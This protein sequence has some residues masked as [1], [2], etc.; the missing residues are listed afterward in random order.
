VPPRADNPRGIVRAIHREQPDC[1]VQST[2][3][4]E[5]TKP[6]A[7]SKLQKALREFAERL[8]MT[9]GE[10]EKELTQIRVT[11]D[12]LSPREFPVLYA[13]PRARMEHVDGCGWCQDFHDGFYDIH[14]ARIVFAQFAA[15][16]KQK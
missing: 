1:A 13:L 9:P 4:T 12:C 5:P 8:G 10:L 6:M 15:Y 16:K 11:E 14:D 3:S 7:E 2:F